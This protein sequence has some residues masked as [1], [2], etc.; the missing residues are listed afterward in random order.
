MLKTKMITYNVHD[1]GRKARGVDRLF[2]TAALAAL[3]N[4]PE[5]QERVKLGDMLGYYGHWPRLA[6]GMATREVGLLDGKV[7]ALPTA[8]RTIHLSADEQGNI[9]HQA[10]FLDNAWG[11]EAAGHYQS[12]A[13]GFSSAIDVSPRSSPSIPTDF[14]GF[15]YVLEPNYTTNRGHRAMLDAVLTG[16]AQQGEMLEL[17]DAVL[18][19]ST[20]QMKAKNAMF[21]TL[22]AQHM[23]ALET[24]ERVSRDNDLLIGR[25]ARGGTAVLDDILGTGRVAPERL[26]VGAPTDFERFRSVPLA[27]LQEPEAEEDSRDDGAAFLRRRYGFK[28]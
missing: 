5:V 21:D 24:L 2:D 25:L 3:I 10:E 22:H 1:R 23:R 27:A 14:H 13:G 26:G 7:V 16:E 9:S 11:Q 6:F 18:T 12:E 15:D 28:A 20:A 4:G 19:D 8:L 17:L